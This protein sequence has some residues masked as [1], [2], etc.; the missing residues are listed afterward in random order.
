[1]IESSGPL[2]EVL[3]EILWDVTLEIPSDLSLES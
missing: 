1:V 2:L 3:T